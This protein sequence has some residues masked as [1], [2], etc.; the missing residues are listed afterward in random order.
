MVIEAL[1]LY[2][3]TGSSIGT[4]SHE[5]SEFELTLDLYNDRIPIRSGP[6]W[7]HDFQLHSSVP[8][9]KLSFPPLFILRDEWK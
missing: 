9:V 2:R 5:R 7:R 3:T 1:G 8:S 4:Q 6:N